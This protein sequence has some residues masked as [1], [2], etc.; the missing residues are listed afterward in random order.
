[1]ETSK[2]QAA[3][4]NSEIQKKDMAQV[5]FDLSEGQNLP[6]TR[7]SLQNMFLDHY[8]HVEGMSRETATENWRFIDSVLCTI[9]AYKGR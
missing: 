8:P 1:M 2:N 9:E 7:E 6:A 5:L 3:V 4:I